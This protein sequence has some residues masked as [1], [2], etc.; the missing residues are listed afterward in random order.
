MNYPILRASIANCLWALWKAWNEARVDN[1]KITPSD[2]CHKDLA[3]TA[4]YAEELLSAYNDQLKFS[5]DGR[6]L[7]KDSSN[8][9][10]MDLGLRKTKGAVVLLVVMLLVIVHLPVAGTLIKGMGSL[11]R[12]L[13]Y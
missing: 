11:V 13:W 9:I 10:Q 3:L 12:F 5:L 6:N 2:V 1:A 4:S 7:A 8:L